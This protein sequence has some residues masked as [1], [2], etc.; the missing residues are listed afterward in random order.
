VLIE[1][2]HSEVDM[3]GLDNARDILDNEIADLGIEAYLNL[4][5]APTPAAV[6][7]AIDAGFEF[8]HLDVFQDDPGATDADVIAA[9]REV[10]E[11]ARRT[12]ALVEG[13]PRYLGGASTVHHELVDPA[14]AA[15]ALT[16]PA[17]AHSFVE[18]T[19]IDTLAIGIGNVHGRYPDRK[20]LDLGLLA[21]LRAAI[22]GDVNLSL[23]GGSDT[24]V[25]TYRAVARGGVGKI[26]VNSDVRYAFRH[27]LEHQFAAH[28]DEYATAKLLGPI[29][30]A[31]QRVV[32][33]KIHAFGS[34]GKA[35]PAGR[36]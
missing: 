32:V 7:S 35:R 27:A 3:L 22:P 30:D 28:P 10:V 29:D 18:A 19:G 4:D 20:R 9:T 16:S 12:G 5:H 33:T 13:E 11:H 23:H 2:S 8:V 26:N 24:P 14:V 25:P 21:R 6:Q 34:A 1:L 31:V 36:S 15:A 17:G